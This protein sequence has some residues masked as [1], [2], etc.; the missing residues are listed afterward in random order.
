MIKIL[1]TASILVGMNTSLNAQN[2]NV[3]SH[4]C[5]IYSEDG[6]KFKLIVQGDT[7]NKDFA[8]QVTYSTNLN[9]FDAKL[10]FE[11]TVYDPLK[12][13]IQTRYIKEG[14]PVGSSYQTV[15]KLIRK[16]QKMKL[17]IETSALKATP[18][19]GNGSTII[20]NNAQPEPQNGVNIRV[21]R[22]RIGF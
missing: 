3:V 10:I 17:R 15:Y 1:L 13:T 7:I 12:A 18:Q 11:N 14:H 4:D 8:T 19:N 22:S 9:L 16:K 2:T 20:I 21:G 6:D 5:K